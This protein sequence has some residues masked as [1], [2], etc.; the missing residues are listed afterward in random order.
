M[1]YGLKKNLLRSQLK[2]L[3]HHHLQTIKTKVVM[4]TRKTIFVQ[5]AKKRMKRVRSE[6]NVMFILNS[7]ISTALIKG[8]VI[9]LPSKN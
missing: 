9:F 5:S 1:I 6:L 8:N 4:K 2:S 7:F 3:I